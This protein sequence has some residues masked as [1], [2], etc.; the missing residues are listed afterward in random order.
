[1]IV[2]IPPTRF[3]EAGNILEH[4]QLPVSDLVSAHW[5][6]FIG[7]KQDDELVATA[8]L[9]VCDGVLLLRSVATAPGHRGRGLASKLVAE[10]HRRASRSGF[11]HAY[12]LTMDA[13]G[14]FAERFGYRDVQRSR[15]PGGIVGSAQFSRLCPDSARLMET[16]L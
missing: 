6:A 9:E 8:G 15:A 3:D 10:L 14:Y 16:R 5:L 1:M 4:C 7:W 13:A 2:D 12:L 11:S